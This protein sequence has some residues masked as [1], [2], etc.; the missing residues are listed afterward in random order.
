M[1]K[2]KVE[3]K[4]YFTLFKEVKNKSDGKVTFIYSPEN[5]GYKCSY[6]DRYLSIFYVE[7]IDKLKKAGLLLDCFTPICCLCKRYKKLLSDY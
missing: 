7:I 3:E 6:C 1:I 2:I 4:Y 5:S